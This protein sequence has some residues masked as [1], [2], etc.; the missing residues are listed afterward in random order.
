MPTHMNLIRSAIPAL[1]LAFSSAATHAAVVLTVN[2]T[3]P[4]TDLLDQFNFVDNATIP[5][6]TFNQQAFSDNSGPPGQTFTT[7]LGATF[8][9]SFSYKG[10]NTGGTN[11]GGIS[12]A[13]TTWG[14]R[15]SLVGGTTLTPILTVT[16]IATPSVPV[17]TEW[18]TW[19][20]SGAD[21]LTLLPSST[22]AVEVFSSQGYL[23]F[24]A[25]TDPNSYPGGVAFN[26]SAP[27]RTFDGSA[28]QDRGY[29]RTF[30]ADLIAVP[31]PGA[32]AALFGGVALL[33]SF[34]RRH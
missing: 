20:F 19:A 2:A 27:I 17:G 21:L 32:F 7:G 12:V 15:V 1:A 11:I 18:L 10:A 22:Y 5:G 3:T 26:T 23:G 14:L 24:D 6:G 25:A 34:R 13:T 9:Q 8:L 33:G 29:D 4:A 30:H 16:N 31:E 28:L